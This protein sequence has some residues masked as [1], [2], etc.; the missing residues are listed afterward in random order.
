MDLIKN[1]FKGDKIIWMIFGILC[2][3]SIVE[4]FSAASTLTYK[5]GDHW[6]PISQHVTHLTA[7]IIIMLLVQNINYNWFKLFPYFL[8]PLSYILLTGLTVMSVLGINRINSASRWLMVGGLQF[9]PSEIAKVAIITAVALI[10]G[11]HQGEKHATSKAFRYIMTA[12]GPICLLIIFENFSTAALLIVVIF[13]M[14]FIGRVKFWTLLKSFIVALL[15]ILSLIGISRIAPEAP[16]LHRVATWT[17]RFES[18]TKK[19]ESIPPAKFDMDKNGQRGHANIAIASSNLIGVGPGNSVQRDFL[20]QAFSD[21]I[22]A[23]I[24]EELGLIGGGFVTLL[25]IWLL[26]RIGKVARKC[27]SP[28]AI[29]LIFGIGILLVTQAMVNMLVA[30]GAIPVTGQPLPLISKGGTSTLV[31][32]G[33]IAM[34]LSVSHAANQQEKAEYIKEEAERLA[35]EHDELPTQITENEVG[36]TDTTE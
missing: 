4:V 7:G 5:S 25:Y 33:L 11:K 20:S 21:F 9:Q 22:F 8:I 10:L 27:R 16:F 3:I 26:I 13:S 30:V 12:T 32:C 23:I 36:F 35:L 19:K 29:L 34:V 24:I 17:S 2:V 15:I 14:L 18:F 28:F 6:S 31:N 1:I